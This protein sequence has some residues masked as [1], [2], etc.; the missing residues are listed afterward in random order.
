VIAFVRH[1]ETA[2]NVAGAL[3]GRTDAE[4]T[5]RGRAQ[6]AALAALFASAPVL[7]VVTSPLRRATATAEVIA[8][9]H[10]LAVDIDERLIEIDYGSWEGKNPAELGSAGWERWRLDP[11][12]APPGAESLTALQAR[13]VPACADLAARE[14]AGGV[15]VA[16][17]HVSPVKAAV[18]WALAV[19][20]DIAWRMHLQVAAVTRIGVRAGL[21]FLLSFNET[22]HLPA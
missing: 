15:V 11:S 5:D 21:P 7:A 19:G 20:P 3:L 8:G 14:A 22:A 13:V 18:A 17:S 9:P 4:L 12:W 6:A 16:V 1:G 10:G 2:P